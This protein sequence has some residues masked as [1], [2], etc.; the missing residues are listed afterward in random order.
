MAGHDRRAGQHGPQ[1]GG[2]HGLARLRA[3]S[4]EVGGERCVGGQQPL[5]RH[6]RDHVGL[7]EEPLDVDDGE[8]E[9]AQDGIGAVGDGET[10][11]LGEFDRFESG[12]AQGVGGRS[13]LAAMHDVA[14]AE[15]RERPVGQRGEVAARPE[16]AVFGHDR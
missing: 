2:G 7:G 10:L 15:Q 9:H 3:E 16:R 5:D 4:L 12:V 6:R 8:A 1:V 11:L 14:L 13:L